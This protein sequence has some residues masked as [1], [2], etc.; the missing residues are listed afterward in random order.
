MKKYMLISLVGL[1]LAIIIAL[2]I[3]QID[4]D[5]LHA[6]YQIRTPMLTKIAIFIS[7]S[8]F[9][10][11]YLTY[12]IILLIT[13]NKHFIYILTNLIII[14]S[15][16]TLIKFII[17]RPRP[18]YFP[19]MVET[20]PSFPSGHS[21]SSM[22]F[23]GSLIYL[24]HSSNIKHKLL[25]INLLSLL[26]L[27]IGLSRIYLG[28]HYPSDVLGGFSIGMILLIINIKYLKPKIK[29]IFR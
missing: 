22:A 6:F 1:L 11:G 2:F 10:Y 8:G 12:F 25:Y 4:N 26:I 28:V 18:Q 14:F 5:F 29:E 23:F 15:T 13:K 17:Q 24:I 16:N 9:I 27:S 19:L 3:P 7:N 20:S 21:I